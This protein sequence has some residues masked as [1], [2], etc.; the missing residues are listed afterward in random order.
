MSLQL[1]QQIPIGE[2]GDLDKARDAGSGPHRD[3]VPVRFWHDQLFAKPPRFGGCVAWHQDY[4]CARLCFKR[5]T[6]CL[7]FRYWTRTRPMNHMTVHVALDDQTVENG[8]L[9]SAR[10]AQNAVLSWLLDG[11]RLCLARI[12]GTAMDSR[13]RSPTGTS[14]T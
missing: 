8:S 13:S 7:D 1:Q 11:R 14:R 5:M 3:M 9:V 12:C 2:L 10:I 6:D 4:S